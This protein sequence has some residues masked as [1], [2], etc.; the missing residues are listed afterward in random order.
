MLIEETF[1]LSCSMTEFDDFIDKSRKDAAGWIGFFWG[2]TPDELK[3]SKSLGDAITR[4]WLEFF[5]KKAK[6]MRGE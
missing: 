4:S 5:H 3:N 2:Q 6:A 1:P